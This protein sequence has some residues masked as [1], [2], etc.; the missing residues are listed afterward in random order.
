M[1]IESSGQLTLKLERIPGVQSPQRF[2][3]SELC[4]ACSR[5]LCRLNKNLQ[6]W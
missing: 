6:Q 4:F 2:T 5:F 3:L 1:G